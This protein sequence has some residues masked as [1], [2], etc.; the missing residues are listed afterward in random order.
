ML[1]S[2]LVIHY[3]WNILIVVIQCFYIAFTVTILFAYSKI[4]HR[5]DYFQEISLLWERFLGGQWCAKGWFDSPAPS[6]TTG[7]TRPQ[8]PTTGAVPP[9]AAYQRYNS[10]ANWCCIIMNGLHRLCGCKF[11]WST[12]NMCL[13]LKGT[14][15]IICIN[16]IGCP[17]SLR[18]SLLKSV[19]NIPKGTLVYLLQLI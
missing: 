6:T 10:T 9:S 1:T 12:C 16:S 11:C 4:F 15:K 18:D 3:F 19:D 2:T 14:D 17:L 5:S 13:T 8:P 7:G